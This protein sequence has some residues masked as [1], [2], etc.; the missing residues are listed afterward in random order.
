MHWIR[1]IF[2]FT[3]PSLATAMS[4]EFNYKNKKYRWMCFV[5]FFSLTEAKSHCRWNWAEKQHEREAHKMSSGSGK[6]VFSA[7]FY[8][9]KVGRRKEIEKVFPSFLLLPPPLCWEPE[10][11]RQKLGE[12]SSESRV[13]LFYS[14]SSFSVFLFFFRREVDGERQWIAWNFRNS[15]FQIFCAFLFTAALGI[16]CMAN[17]H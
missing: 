13:H 11:R 7:P 10:R 8:W 16:V 3:L 14:S 17:N 1:S 15:T 5:V 9:F 12:N 6:K 2:P 4:E